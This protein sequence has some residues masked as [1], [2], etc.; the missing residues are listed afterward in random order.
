MLWPTAETPLSVLY[1]VEDFR[2][3]ASSLGR[4]IEL[5]HVSGLVGAAP[6]RDDHLKIGGDDLAARFDGE[7]DK[8]LADASR[9]AVE[10]GSRVGRGQGRVPWIRPRSSG[11]FADDLNLAL[12]QAAFIGGGEEFLSH[13]AHIVVEVGH[14]S[15]PPAST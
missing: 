9:G 13:R 5:E 4:A 12:T 15:S 7:A 8:V 14:V 10:R 3:Q 1:H 6:W 2:P 11:Y